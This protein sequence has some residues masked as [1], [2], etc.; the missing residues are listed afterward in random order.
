MPAGAA[1]KQPGPSQKNINEDH[2]NKE[3]RGGSD[4]GLYLVIV[5]IITGI[6]LY[7][8]AK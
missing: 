3:H 6:V 2:Y 5:S 8:F 1:V 4:S 7:L